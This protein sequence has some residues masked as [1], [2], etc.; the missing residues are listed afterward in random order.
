MP[1]GRCLIG[2]GA[3]SGLALGRAIWWHNKPVNVEVKTISNPSQEVERLLLAIQKA[4][5]Q[6][7]QLRDQAEQRMGKEE[8]AVFDAHLA[9]LDDPAFTGE[10]QRR[11]LQEKKNAE[12][13]C[14]SL[15]EEMFHMFSSIPDEY[16]R[17]RAD[18][19]QDVGNRLLHLLSGSK[20]FDPQLLSPGSIV[21]AQELSPSDTALLPSQVAALVLGQGSKTS[22]TAIMARALGIPTVLGLGQAVY[23]IKDGDPLAINGDQGTVITYPDQKL[24]QQI[25]KELQEKQAQQEKILKSAAQEGVTKD[26]KQIKVMANI[27]ST[28]E[29]EIALKYGAEGIGLFRTEFL[30]LDSNSWPSEEKQFVAYRKVLKSFFPRPVIIRTLDIGGDKSL[31][32]ADLPQEENPFL[33]H[34]GI[35]YCLSHPSIFKTQLRALLRA[36]AYG[37]LR[38]MIPMVENINEIRAVKVLLKE[39]RQE[40]LQRNIPMGDLISLGI[41]IEVPATALMAD[42]FVSEVDFVSIGTNDLTQ[43]TL[44]ADRDNERVAHYYDPLHPAVLQLIK[45]TCTAANKAGIPVGLCGE[46]ANDPQATELLIGLG[47]NE[48]S[49][50]ATAIPYVKDKLRQLNSVAAKEKAHHALTLEDVASVHKLIQD[51][52]R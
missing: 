30:Y 36:S 12:A 39:C 27:G 20:P 49:M 34:R 28:N 31:P 9:F 22:H 46:L 17:S 26:G 10:M 50:N 13:I 32:Y 7:S 40:L 48:L 52:N 41:M 1:T 37:N 19:I 33:G 25:K 24:Q 18:D 6:I 5:K 11:I 35:R 29:T 43:Y 21:I 23:E 4:K 8:A 3:A 16:M 2:I 44:A 51:K 14:T 15:T 42:R 47:V 38:I 45:L